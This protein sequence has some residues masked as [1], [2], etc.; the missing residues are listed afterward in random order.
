MDEATERLQALLA[1]LTNYERTRPDKPRF[2]LDTMHALLARL[3]GEARGPWRAVQVG[4]SKGKGTTCAYLERI[5]RA[6][7]LRT[8]VFASPHVSTIL[9][10]VRLDG[11]LIDEELFTA[12]CRRVLEVAANLELAPSFFEVTTAAA[13]L[14]FRRHGADIAILEVGLGGRLDATTAVPV[15]LGVL[16]GVELEH[17][18]LLGDTVEAI[19]AEKAFVFR[20]GGVGLHACRQPAARVA[21]AHA[22]RVGCRVLREGEDFHAVRRAASED[23]CVEFDIVAPGGEAHRMHV[24]GDPPQH[25][26]RAVALA[27]AAWV[28][29]FPGH[30]LPPRIERPARPGRFEVCEIGEQPLVLDGA[31]TEDSARCLASALRARFP[32]CGRV[33]LVGFARGKRWREALAAL[34][35]EDANFLCAE[36]PGTASEDPGALADWLRAQGR[37]ARVLGPTEDLRAELLGAA[38][39]CGAVAVVTGSFYLVGAVRP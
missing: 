24:A 32:A 6:E 3:G 33:F 1:P 11:A 38:A 28:R 14:A 2:T 21:E 20:A 27:T 37:P 22:D 10:R 17:T 39:A 15:D 16:T 4:G 9:E 26:D 8:G 18:E 25:E 23:G 12:C 31:H 13:L 5:A 30:G 7:G 29:L 34:V 35:G 19:A 36:V